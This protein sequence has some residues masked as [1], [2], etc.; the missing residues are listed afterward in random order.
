[1]KFEPITPEPLL[2]N[3]DIGRITQVVNNL[4]NNAVKFT[5]EGGI[6]LSTQIKKDNHNNEVFKSVKDSGSGI[7]SEILPKLFPSLLQSQ[8]REQDLGLYIS[9][10]I[11]EAHDG[12]IWVSNNN[13]QGATFSFSLP[14][15][16]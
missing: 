13:R 2:I 9:K 15:H 12:R 3:A 7:D 8:N 11:I 6:I 1:V 10:S 4:L 16:Q 14:I 5:K